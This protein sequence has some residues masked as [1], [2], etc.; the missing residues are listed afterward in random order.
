MESLLTIADN[1]EPLLRRINMQHRRKTKKLT[2]FNQIILR[3][4][5]EALCSVNN[6]KFTF[7]GIICNE[8]NNNNNNN[9]NNNETRITFCP[10]L[11][12]ACLRAEKRISINRTCGTQSAFFSAL[13]LN[14]YLEYRA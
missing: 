9:N 4:Q 2:L 5:Q 8:D 14:S 11:I 6:Y 1:L 12:C 7:T 13:Y 3:F 10:P